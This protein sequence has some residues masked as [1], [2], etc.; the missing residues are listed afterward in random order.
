MSLFSHVE[1]KIG[2]HIKAQKKREKGT[3]VYIWTRAMSPLM[4]QPNQKS[5][6]E[7][8]M[9]DKDKKGNIDVTNL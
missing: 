6:F 5:D 9:R 8:V 4:A 3:P 2:Q 1:N 7:K